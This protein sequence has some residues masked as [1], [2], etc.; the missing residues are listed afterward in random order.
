MI[1]AATSHSLPIT[2]GRAFVERDEEPS[3]AALQH[4]ERTAYMELA[5][6]YNALIDLAPSDAVTLKSARD[7][8]TRRTGMWA[9]ASQAYFAALAKEIDG[10]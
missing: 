4:V 9:A 7:R 5:R 8:V 6:A 10:Q 1:D 2:R 3:L